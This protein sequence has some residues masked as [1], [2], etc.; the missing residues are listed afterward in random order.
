VL[1]KY[2][3]MDSSAKTVLLAVLLAGLFFGVLHLSME[4]SLALSVV[5][6]PL[7]LLAAGRLE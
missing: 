7:V 1:L 5:I 4:A 3:T 2:A 6:A